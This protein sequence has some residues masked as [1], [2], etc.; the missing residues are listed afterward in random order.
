MKRIIGSLC[1]IGIVFSAVGQI[2]EKEFADP[3]RDARPS[4]YWEWMNGNINK[5]GLTA[6]LEYMK[7]ANYG[8]AMI[9]DAGVGIPRG[10]VDYNSPQWQEAVMHALKEAERLGM[11]F[12]MNL[13]NNYP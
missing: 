2:S 13:K 6:D 3:P 8:A 9:F 5:E 7:C 11:H 4:T 1:F 12:C 10:P